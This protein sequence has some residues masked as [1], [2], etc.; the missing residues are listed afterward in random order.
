MKTT[1]VY[2]ILSIVLLGVSVWLFS[3]IF[4]YLAIAVVLSAIMRPVM[5]YFTNT[6]FL[7]ASLPKL[8][9]V[10][11]SYAVLIS[12]L[13]SF[14]LLFIPL[15]SEQVK[16]LSNLNYEELY[17]S[18]TTPLRNVE[19][20]L[21]TNGLISE[22]PGFIVNNLKA[23]IL[24]LVSSDRFSNIIN[25][26]VSFT[27]QFFLGI[28]AV[29]FISFFL[30][31]EMN[32]IRK[33]L[34]SFIPNK[35]FEV[36]ITAYSKIE[37]LLS[38]YLTGLLI[39]MFSLF[40]L[41][42]LGLSILGI[43]YSLTIALFAAVANLIP[44]LGPIFGAAFGILVGIS[45]GI[46]NTDLQAVFILVLKVASVFAGVQI[47]DNILLQP[48][49]FSRS[50]KAHPLEIFIIIFVAGS[51]AGISGMVAAIPCYTVLKVSF[52][53]LNEGYRSYKI[54]KT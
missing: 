49:I 14:F 41:A 32:S 35:Y 37:Q 54:F 9:A 20:Y 42:A 4:F 16:V 6:Q 53:E 30:L 15:I 45:V 1:S 36:T 39:Q 28:L 48:I 10:I 51:L 38:N 24:D 43:K 46:D 13:A 21:I 40:S 22:E 29:T 17:E 33:K 11:L 7:G 47:A 52:M 26:I 23:S 31:Y 25:T 8:L 5:R 18:L 12:L 3:D 44:Y 2:L 34:I 27:G 50:V 19:S